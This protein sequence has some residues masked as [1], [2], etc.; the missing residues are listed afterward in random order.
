V[1]RREA[2]LAPCGRIRERPEA[3]RG[4]PAGALQERAAKQSRAALACSASCSVSC[5]S[6]RRVPS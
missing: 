1:E 6:G 3:E 2:D 4:R 5:P